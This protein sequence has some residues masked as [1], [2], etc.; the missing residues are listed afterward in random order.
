MISAGDSATSQAI[1]RAVENY[2]REHEGSNHATSYRGTAANTGTKF[3]GFLAGVQRSGLTQ[4]L[5]D[6]G[7][8]NLVGKPAQEVLRGLNDYLVGPG[9]LLEEDIARWALFDYQ[10]EVLGAVVTYMDLEAALSALVARE[11]LGTVLKSFFGYY[12]YRRFKT[13]FSERI[14]KAAGGLQNTKE[15]FRQI[16]EMIMLKLSV[17]TYGQDLTALNWRGQEGNDLSQSILTSVFNVFGGDG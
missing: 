5:F 9:S 4:T 13:H 10:E 3:G 11:N 6:S 16:K 8:G 12:L 2:V 14:L 17:L 15:R 1:G 7:L